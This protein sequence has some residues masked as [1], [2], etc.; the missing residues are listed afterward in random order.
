MNGTVMLR[1][2]FIA[3]FNLIINE[4]CYQILALVERTDRKFVQLIP[5]F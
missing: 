1:K 4:L 5:S 2:G 3:S